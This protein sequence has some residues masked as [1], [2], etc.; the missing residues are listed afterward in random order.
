M[1]N[2][3]PSRVEA[4]NTSPPASHPSCFSSIDYFETQENRERYRREPGRCNQTNGMDA[5]H[6]RA[7]RS[8]RQVHSVLGNTRSIFA[9]IRGA[10]V[11]KCSFGRSFIESGTKKHHRS[12]AFRS[13][14]KFVSQ[15]YS[16]VDEGDRKRRHNIEGTMIDFATAH[17]VEAD[18]AFSVRSRGR[19][20]PTRNLET[21]V[22][23]IARS[24]GQVVATLPLALLILTLTPFRERRVRWWIA[25]SF[26]A[27]R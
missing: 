6:S 17:H 14:R 21:L 1:E 20:Q 16:P 12:H 3:S 22:L 11:G 5:V 8:K 9:A 27:V 15:L 23:T 7:R 25:Q 19:W 24:K 10:G 18:F 4:S 26:Q 2:V 13:P